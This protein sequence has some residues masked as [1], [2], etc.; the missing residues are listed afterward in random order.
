MPAGT[1]EPDDADGAGTGFC[2]KLPSHGDFLHRRV[3]PKLL[4]RW[5][6]WVDAG[7]DASR[8]ELGDDWLRLYLSCPV[9][10]FAAST[11]CFGDTAAAGVLMPSVD[12]IGRYHPLAIV[13]ALPPGGGPGAL[14]AQAAWYDEVEELALSCLADD[15][16]FD[17]FDARLAALP[18]PS[19][20][21]AAAASLVDIFARIVDAQPVAVSL[22][23]TAGSPAAPAL[24][25]GY[26]GLPQPEDFAGLIS[27]AQP[28][29]IVPAKA[30]AE[31]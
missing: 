28:P 20:P 29:A 27:A 6:A 26:P 23:W 18:G 8:A 10:R 22:W 14:I 13:S 15:F 16:V 3:P 1:F 19:A 12:R 17:A 2:G 24:Y 21:G 7:L 5:E 9:W 30:D 31:D 4:R 25:R 11:A